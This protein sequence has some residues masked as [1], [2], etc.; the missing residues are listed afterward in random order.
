MGTSKI[1]FA[2]LKILVLNEYPINTI[3]LG[4][5]I[6]AIPGPPVSQRGIEIRIHLQNLFHPIM[7]SLLLFI[8]YS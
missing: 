3:L 1:K 6:R 5:K 2:K 7:Q 8:I 4:T